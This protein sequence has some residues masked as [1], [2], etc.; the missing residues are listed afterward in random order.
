MS[1]RAALDFSCRELQLPP[2]QP[3]HDAGFDPEREVADGLAVGGHAAV[4]HEAFDLPPA[5]RPAPGQEL[6]DA[7]SAFRAFHRHDLERRPRRLT[8]SWGG[9]ITSGS[10]GSSGAGRRILARTP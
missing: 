2:V 4:Q 1:R 5:S 9:S 7:K 8:G 10:S 6:V 3:D